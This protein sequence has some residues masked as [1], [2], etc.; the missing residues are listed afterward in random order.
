MHIRGFPFGV[1]P[2]RRAPAQAETAE[3]PIR[4]D[5]FGLDRLEAYARVLAESQPVMPDPRRGRLL[6]PRLHQN[7][8]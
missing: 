7:A 4:A 8:R 6:L 3:P 5:V 2:F 1:W